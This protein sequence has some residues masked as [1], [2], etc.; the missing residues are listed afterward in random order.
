MPI[1]LRHDN[2]KYWLKIRQKMVEL[3]P[4]SAEKDHNAR[5]SDPKH[6]FEFL[7]SSQKPIYIVS[8]EPNKNG[9]NNL[10]VCPPRVAAKMLAEGSHR[11]ATQQ[12]AHAWIEQQAE[13]KRQ[14]EA[15]ES[16][17]Q[18]P[19]VTELVSALAGLGE[20]KRAGGKQSGASPQQS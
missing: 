20:Q 3:D 7:E 16:K 2:E 19:L 5:L 18:Q 8:D 12:E 1:A 17:K 15:A 14:L 4:E 6:K 13:Q 10:S 9:S 11:V